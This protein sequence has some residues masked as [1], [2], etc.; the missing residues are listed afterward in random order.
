MAAAG[1]ASAAM[2]SAT[3]V[4]AHP[5]SLATTLVPFAAPRQPASAASDAADQAFA[6]AGPGA[7]PSASSRR[8][9]NA[10]FARAGRRDPHRREMAA[11]S[12]GVGAPFAASGPLDARP[13]AE[14]ITFTATRSALQEASAT[15]A[16][17]RCSSAAS[18]CAAVT[19]GKSPAVSQKSARAPLLAPSLEGLAGSAS[20]DDPA[21]GGMQAIPK[22]ERRSARP[23]LSW[24]SRAK[25]PA[26]LPAGS[27]KASQRAA[28]KSGLQPVPVLGAPAP[29]LA[30]G[31]LPASF[32]A[33][34]P[35]SASRCRRT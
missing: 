17:R 10:D 22:M 13:S 35:A 7:P 3:E 31:P 6:A 26:A 11:I 21:A 5:A 34:C 15:S 30:A 23:L 24:G 25:S 9:L 2:R 32:A 16:W 33:R 4:R 14:R 29:G 20:P 18:R 8:A 1:D 12:S 28:S 27:P 19:C